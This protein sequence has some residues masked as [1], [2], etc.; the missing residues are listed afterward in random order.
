[1]QI[2]KRDTFPTVSSYYGSNT[3]N[4][5]TMKKV[6]TEKT[7]NAF[8]K[9]QDEGIVISDKQADE[10]AE[11]MKQWAIDKG[12]TAYTHWFQPMT[13]LTAEKHDGFI[14]VNGKDQVLE[15]FSGSK[16]IQGEPDASSFPSGGT[17]STFEARGYTAW[18]PSSPAFI[19]EVELGK[20]LCIPSIFVSYTG[21]AMPIQKTSTPPADRN[22]NIS[23]S[24]S[25]T[26]SCARICSSPD[27][28]SLERHPP[29]VS[30]LRTSTSVP[31]KNA[32]SIT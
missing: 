19:A 8:K 25:A 2:C 1:L 10:I 22:R 16:L 24:T 21:E 31:L 28:R 20:T 14:S 5:L 29:R 4:E 32:S 30:S 27:V 23:S 18:D 26:T 9:W 11:A 7:F 3:F 15:K 13:G 6:I 17:R 12:A